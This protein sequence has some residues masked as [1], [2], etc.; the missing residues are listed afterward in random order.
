MQEAEAELLALAA[1]DAAPLEL[2]RDMMVS[3]L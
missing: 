2:C 3:W 1:H